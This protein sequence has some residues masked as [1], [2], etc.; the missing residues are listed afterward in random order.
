LLQSSKGTNKHARAGYTSRASLSKKII[1]RKHGKWVIKEVIMQTQLGN[2]QIQPK[3]G[4]K[5]IRRNF[6]K[7]GHKLVE[8]R[9]KGLQG[10]RKLFNFN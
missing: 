9:A 2:A 4:Q 6:Y 5:A 7:F 8:S 10:E 3:P 1:D